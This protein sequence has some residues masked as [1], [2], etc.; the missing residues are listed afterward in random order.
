MIEGTPEL[1]T[2]SVRSIAIMSPQAK[3]EVL[4]KVAV[5]LVGGAQAAVR[6]DRLDTNAIEVA[7]EGADSFVVAIEDYRLAQRAAE[8]HGGE[9][10][11]ETLE[12]RIR[13][14]VE[15]EVANEIGGRPRVAML[16]DA[17]GCGYWRMALPARHLPSLY[18]NVTSAGIPVEQLADYETVFVQRHHRWSDCS[19]IEGLV[20]DGKRVV[21]D[22]DDD[23]WTIPD[24]NPA[25]KSFRPKDLQAAK[26]IM[27]RVH[28]ITTTNEVLRERLRRRLDPCPPIHVIPNALDPQGP[29]VPLSRIGS[30]DGVRR[31]LWQ[32]SSSHVR[33]WLVATAAVDRVMQRHDDVILCLMGYMPEEVMKFLKDPYRPWWTPDRLEYTPSCGVDQYFQIIPHLR[34][35]VALAPLI[36][37]EF[38]ESKSECK[39]VEYSLVGIPSV[40]S[41]VP[42]YERS[43]PHGTHALLAGDS[44]NEW[45]QRIETLLDDAALR[46]RLVRASR[47]LVA[48]DYNIRKVARQ[49]R[50]VLVAPEK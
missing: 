5:S 35:E 14:E 36:D 3:I 50:R 29:W 30:P 1:S 47:K 19:L 9:A 28:A 23:L 33:D 15:A 31:I 25:C 7:R 48:S 18:C 32:G 8:R 26:A 43:V 11:D 38:N 17:S 13:E 41:R 21:Y 49:W 4:P 34:A 24:H 39:W 16:S 27:E 6:R 10:P 46:R 2:T 37:D 42:C 45:E 20:R 44:E 40:L 22:I 12:A